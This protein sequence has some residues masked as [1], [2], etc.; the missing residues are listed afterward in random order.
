MVCSEMRD[1]LLQTGH[2]RLIILDVVAELHPD[3]L[4]RQR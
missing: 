1:M 3:R 4:R 2:P